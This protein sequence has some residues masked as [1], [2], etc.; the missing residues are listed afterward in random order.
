ME[1][2]S[3]YKIVVYWALRVVVYS[4]MNYNLHV[5]SQLP[6]LCMSSLPLYHVYFNRTSIHL[7]FKRS[8]HLDFRFIL[9]Y[10]GKSPKINLPIINI[11][12]G[13]CVQVGVVHRYVLELRISILFIFPSLSNHYCHCL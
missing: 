9:E 11:I 3:H 12:R 13:S 7:Y 2:E 8:C 4:C 5:I 10:I 1:I 6:I